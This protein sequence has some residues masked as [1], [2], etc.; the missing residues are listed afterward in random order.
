MIKKVGCTNPEMRLHRA[1]LGVL[2]PVHQPVN[3]GMH[4]RA[5]AHRTRFYGR[6]QRGP[7]KTVV[8][9][10]LGGFPDRDDLCVSRR[11]AFADDRV[12]TPSDHDAVARYDCS[13]RDF[14]VIAGGLSFG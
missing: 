9:C 13:D 11:I 2:C 8:A 10:C 5:R 7:A 12:P 4:K 1:S 3:P 14:A 6:V